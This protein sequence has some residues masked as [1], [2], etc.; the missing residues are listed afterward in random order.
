MGIM[1]NTPLKPTK[2][3]VL[4]ILLSTR[5]FRYSQK[6][7]GVTETE[8]FLLGWKTS[9]NSSHGIALGA[10]ARTGFIYIINHCV[11]CIGF[12]VLNQPFVGCWWCQK[13]GAILWDFEH[14]KNCVFI[15][16]SW[17]FV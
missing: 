6:I 3:N 15:A 5:R 14:M 1:L 13:V 8:S 10:K 17:M 16:R 7:L 2:G 12:S 4:L 11:C 9:L